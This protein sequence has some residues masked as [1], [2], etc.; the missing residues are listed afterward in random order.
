MARK[1][2]KGLL[3]IGYGPTEAEAEADLQRKLRGEQKA[4]SAVLSLNGNPPTLHEVSDSLWWPRVARLAPTTQR[5]Y[6]DLY[7]QHIRDYLGHLPVTL[8]RPLGIQEW[9]D[10]LEREKVTA[11]TR[12]LARS[13][14]RNILD[15]ACAM[16]LVERNAADRVRVE[17]P[18]E[19]R[20]RVLT[21]EQAQTLLDNVAGTPL[22]APVYLA[23]VLGL[24]RGEIC[25]LKWDHFDRRKKSLYISEQRQIVYKVPGKKGQPNDY[26]R[27]L[28]STA[29]KRTLNLL[30][31]MVEAIDNRGNLDQPYIAT[32]RSGAQWRPD[33][34]TECWGGAREKLGL[35][36]WRFHDLRHGAAGL[37]LAAGCDLF[38]I[39][40]ILGH[41]DIDTS[42]LYAAL[43][44]SQVKSAMNKMPVLR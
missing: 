19:K 14:L 7:A 36:H 6:A 11:N 30:E 4:H 5:R 43:H 40:A 27:E 13:V 12:F 29:S 41:S 32:A 33:T 8:I 44:E 38:E 37:L 21:V 3:T 16:E 34:L 1:M 23:M 22:S 17:V 31:W 20:H 26:T 15:R 39:A 42:E 25:A 10:Q 35:P 24:R 18:R 28:K 2:V 9:L